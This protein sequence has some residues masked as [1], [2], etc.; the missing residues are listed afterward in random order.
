MVVPIAPANPIVDIPFVD[1]AA[2]HREIA[3]L[4]TTGFERVM[5]DTDFIGGAEVAAFE[6]ELG[7]WWGREHAIGVGNGT[8][9]IELMLRAAGIEAGDEIVVP[10]NSFVATASAVVRAGAKPV[11]VDVDP[12]HLLI[13]PEEVS[14]HLTQRTRGVLAVHLFGQMAPMEALEEVVAGT[15]VLLFEDAA[16]AHGAR[17]FGSPPGTVGLAAATSFYPGKNLGAYGDAGAVLT[18]RA[19]LARRV[20][21]LGNHGEATKYDHVELGFNS[22]LDTLQA[23]VLRAKLTRLDRW[24]RARQAAADRYHELLRDVPE[25]WL[26]GT[27]PAN[28]HVWHLYPVRLTRR[29]ELLDR[30]RAEGIGVGIHYPVPIAFVGAFRSLGHRRGDFPHAEE[31]ADRLISLPLH[32]HLTSSQQERVAQICASVTR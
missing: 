7:R 26:P 20:R 24:N 23:V 31:A 6:A 19:E 9:A 22:R 4:V 17:R 28:E 3:Q 25:L 27:D 21:L 8:D 16:Q 1:L 14:R 10:A 13:D 29:D 15:Q 12:V 11:F 32:P 18:D 5:V 2:Q 30:L